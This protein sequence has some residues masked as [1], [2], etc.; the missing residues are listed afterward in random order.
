MRT[1]AVIAPLVVTA[2]VLAWLA[3]IPQPAAYHHY[4][5]QR[6]LFGVAHFWNVASNLPFLILGVM[7]LRLNASLSWRVGFL[8]VVFVALGSAYYHL[9]PD[10]PR[11]VWD[12]VPIGIAFAGFYAAVLDEHLALRSVR[13]LAGFTLLSMMAVAWWRYSGDLS[14]WIFVQVG[15]MLGAA[16]MVALLPGRHGH[17]RY[18]MYSLACYAVAKAY[19]F[20]DHSLRT[21]TGGL[22]GGNAFKHLF[23]AAGV[24]CFYRMLELRLNVR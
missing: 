2:L 16:L 1:L 22:T 20:A 17:R 9:A 23:A 21:V 19:E 18:I 8:G 13:W 15:A 5:D 14:A 7:G 12:R 24:W 11:L 6:P 10:D 4:A 3:P